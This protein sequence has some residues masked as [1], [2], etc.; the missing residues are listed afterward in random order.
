MR[1]KYVLPAALRVFAG[2]LF[3]AFVSVGGKYARVGKY[4]RVA[5]LVC[6]LRF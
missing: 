3:D 6:A 1:F 5:K 4:E 2:Y